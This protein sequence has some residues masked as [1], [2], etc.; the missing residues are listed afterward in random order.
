MCRVIVEQSYL[1]E[2]KGVTEGSRG[3]AGNGGGHNEEY[4]KY[5]I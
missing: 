2:Q 5:T 4:G 1:E 3:G